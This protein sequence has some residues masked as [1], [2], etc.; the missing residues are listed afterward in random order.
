M[1]NAGCP[2]YISHCILQW[3]VKRVNG[4]QCMVY[5][6]KCV[7]IH[8]V[9]Y[10]V[11][12]VCCAAYNVQHVVYSVQCMENGAPCTVHAVVCGVLSTEC[13]VYNVGCAE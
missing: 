8:G 4:A 11:C 5:S 2:E 7:E 12:N 9:Y 13:R 10:T 1:Y 3:I 6:V